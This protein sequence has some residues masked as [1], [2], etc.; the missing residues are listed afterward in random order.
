VQHSHQHQCDRLAQVE[1]L[2]HDRVAQNRAG[3]EQV[4]PDVSG[5]P[6]G[7]LASSTWARAAM[8]S[9]SAY[10]AWV[11]QFPGPD[12]FSAMDTTRDLRLI[13]NAIMAGRRRHQARARASHC[14]RHAAY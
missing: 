13:G 6:T 11:V 4:R 12:F 14:H 8:G 1:R 9:L 5:A 10:T 2:A 7:W 3:I